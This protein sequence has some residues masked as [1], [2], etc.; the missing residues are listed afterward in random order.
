MARPKKQ[1]VDY[2]P[3]YCDHGKVLF[4]LENHFKNDGYAVFYKL[5]ELLSKTEGHCYDCSRLENWEYLLSKMGTTEEIVTGIIEKLSAMG[6]V[7]APLWG[8]KRIWMQSFVDSISD[9]YARRKG[10][11]PIKPELSHTETPLG[12]I[13]D[14]GNPQSKVK[15][16]KVNKRKEKDT[17]FILPD[18]IPPETWKAYLAVRIKKRAAQT[19]F[20]L[21]LIIQELEKIKK[22]HGHDPVKVLEKSIKSGWSDVYP[23]K[24]DGN[25]SRTGFTGSSGQAAKK[26]GRA[27]SDGQSYPCDFEG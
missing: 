20:A 16:S 13:T 12:G 17:P 9:V 1:E 6:V 8:E 4:I 15:E 27:E 7:D 2:F 10:D 24:E 5:E 26:T 21:G 18:Y 14:A 19:E 25:G 3:H 11:L 23:L 22:E